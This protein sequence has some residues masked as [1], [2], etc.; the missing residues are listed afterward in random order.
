MISKEKVKFGLKSDQIRSDILALGLE[1]GP[2]IKMPTMQEMCQRLGVSRGTLDA[3]FAPLE[4]RGFFLRKHGSG[5]YVTS[6]IA[7][8]RI[9]LVIGSDIFRFGQSPFYG[10]LIDQCRKRAASHNETFSYYL[11]VENVGGDS[12]LPVH[13]DLADVVEQGQLDG[14][15]LASRRSSEQEAWLRRQCRAVVSMGGEGYTIHGDYAALVRLGV[16]AL[17]AQGCRRIGMI[18]PLGWCGPE[19]RADVQGYRETLASLKLPWRPEWIWELRGAAG[20]ERDS[21]HGT[22]EEQGYRAIQELLGADPHALDGLMIADD[23]M[24]RGALVA[25]RKLGL[26][27]GRDLKIA[28]HVTKGSPALSEQDDHLVKVELDPRELVDHAFGMLEALMDGRPV[29]HEKIVV[30]PR[31]IETNGDERQNFKQQPHRQS[32]SQEAVGAQ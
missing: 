8:K 21:V 15:L 26:E 16:S 19:A 12:G 30:Q 10:L 29:P 27:I 17:A 20:I 1:R 11:D 28:T 31:L 7:Q 14:V 32:L 13:Q 23:M 5:I 2:G 24:T 6:R 25:L 22:R 4:Q 9:G 18:T 3:A